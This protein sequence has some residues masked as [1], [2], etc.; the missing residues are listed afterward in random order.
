MV[1]SALRALLRT[2]PSKTLPPVLLMLDEFAQLGYLPP[3]ENA[4]GIARGFGV[5]LWPFLQDLNQLRALYK[6]RWETFIGARGA[7][8]AFAP[9]DWST[10]EYLARLAGQ[11]TKLVESWNESDDL[12][13]SGREGRNWAPQGFPLFRPEEL[14]GMGA[15]R[16]LCFVDPV[17]N[18]FF[19]EAPGYWDTPYGA[20]LDR[21]PYYG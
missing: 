13:G 10:A 1:V 16:M 15:G 20:G 7:L 12:Q 2:P 4:M 11:T 18:P 17:P 5:Q 21:N 8:T 9:Q 14:M 3:I 19:T 6:A